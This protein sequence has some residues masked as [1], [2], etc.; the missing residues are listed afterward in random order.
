MAMPHAN[1]FNA[2]R[3]PRNHI[4]Q[5]VDLQGSGEYYVQASLPAPTVNVLCVG[6]SSKE[7]SPL[8][9][10]VTDATTY[11]PNST[12]VDEIFG[13][14]N[15]STPYFPKLP[16]EYNSIVHIPPAWGPPAVSLLIT[17]PKGVTTNEHILCSIRTQLYHNCTTW[18]KVAMSGGF[19]TVHCDSDTQNTMPYGKDHPE[20]PTGSWESDWKDVGGEWIRSLALNNGV[21]D[22]NASSARVLS[23]LTPEYSDGVDTILPATK[24]STGEG[25]GVLAASTVLLSTLHAP[26]VHSWNYNGTTILDTPQYESFKARFSYKDYAS[27]GSQGWQ[28]IFYVILTAVFLSNLGALVYLI[29]QFNRQGYI[30]DYTEPQNLFAIAVNSPPSSALA[31]ACGG[32]PKGDVLAKKWTVDMARADNTNVVEGFSYQPYGHGHGHGYGYSGSNKQQH[33]HFYLR[34]KDDGLTPLMGFS[35]GTPG[36]VAGSGSSDI[37]GRGQRRSRPPTLNAMVGRSSA[38]SSSPAVEQFNRLSGLS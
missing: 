18:Y 10:N 14:D 31:G 33:P 2:V 16:I 13:W 19:L 29:W 38:A 17:P 9:V 7:L 1:L 6:M 12:I 27:G 24:P 26:F 21:S 15:Q 5:P 8:I 28:G 37:R 32:G 4:L 30:T 20:A 25:L 35:P 3:E 22:A 23:Q 36:P 34:C 11:I